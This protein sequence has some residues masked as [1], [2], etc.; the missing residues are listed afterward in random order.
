MVV[1]VVPPLF[2]LDTGMYLDTTTGCIKLRG[3]KEHVEK[4]QRSV[5]AILNQHGKDET[6]V[7][8][9]KSTRGC[10][11]YLRYLATEDKVR[12]PSYWKCAQK[13][14]ADKKK[15]VKRNL[16]DPQSPVYKEIES[17]VQKTWEAHKVGHGHDAI[18]LH[19]SKVVVKKI[20]SI[21]N[22]V[23]YRKYDATK[24]GI[25]LQAAQHRCPSVKGLLG[26]S[27]ILT[28]HH[29]MWHLNCYV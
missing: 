1:C 9:I 29:G 6:S 7:E 24:R 28:H 21:Q 3:K 12:Y 20:W 18:G 13:G 22:P 10:Q 5:K 8:H 11:E 15:S 17:L 2:I 27:D 16:I 25:C 23:L 4:M 19:H 14:T 26:E